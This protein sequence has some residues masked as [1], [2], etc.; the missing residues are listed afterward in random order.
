MAIQ[1]YQMQISNLSHTD[2]H[3]RYL[4]L[5]TRSMLDF[6]TAFTVANSFV[7]SS[8]TSVIPLLERLN[9]SNYASLLYAKF[10]CHS[11]HYS[12]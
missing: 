7:H 3:T 11:C 9:H 12:D 6:K 2:M 10:T 8:L 5:R 1:K 4:R